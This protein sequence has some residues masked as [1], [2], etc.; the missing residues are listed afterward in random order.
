[1]QVTLFEIH[2][3]ISSRCIAVS[4]SGRYNNETMH[5]HSVMWYNSIN[6]N[7][8]LFLEKSSYTTY[9]QKHPE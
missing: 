7:F 9:I 2:W 1:M 4:T 3:C 6:V 8:P 5:K